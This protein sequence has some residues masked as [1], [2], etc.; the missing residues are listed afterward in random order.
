MQE[1]DTDGPRSPRRVSPQARSVNRGF[2]DQ[3]WWCNRRVGGH[4]VHEDK[5]GLEGLFRNGQTFA[6]LSGCLTRQLNALYLPQWCFWT[7]GI[8]TVLQ[9]IPFWTFDAI[10][11]DL[12]L[13]TSNLGLLQFYVKS[14]WYVRHS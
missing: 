7:W 2:A 13:K 14:Y 1:N 8:F 6:M 9:F 3:F 10:Y 11:L 5:V 4:S 12:L